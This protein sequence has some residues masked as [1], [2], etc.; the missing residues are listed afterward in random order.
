MGGVLE[1]LLL[2]FIN[3][4]CSCPPLYPARC[5]FFM[6]VW[7]TDCELVCVPV[8]VCIGTWPHVPGVFVQCLATLHLWVV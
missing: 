2:A 3:R 6:V 8:E 7:W 5:L 4:S 1:G